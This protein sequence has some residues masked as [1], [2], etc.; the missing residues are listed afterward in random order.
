MKPA[1]FVYYQPESIE[2]TTS[3]LAEHGDDGKILAGGQSLIPMMNLRLAQP[4]VLIDITKVPGIAD[5]RINGEIRVGTLSRQ[6]SVL[7]SPE[8]Q[9][10]A[11]LIPEALK[12]VGH[13]ANRNRGTFGG[14]IAHADAAAELPAVLLALNGKIVAKSSSKERTIGAD[15]FFESY[16]TTALSSEELLCEVL[17][18]KTEPETTVWGFTEFSRRHGDFALAGVAFTAQMRGANIDSARIALLGVA[19]R[20]VRAIEA[21]NALNGQPFP[22]PAASREIGFLAA[23]ELD[24]PFDQHGSSEYR[25]EL[26]ATLVKRVINQACAERKNS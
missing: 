18:P 23:A 15:D 21:E 5:I 1:P 4:S 7:G 2:E 12:W 9:K 26:A 6:A 11:P 24:P 22:D 20:A 14:S 25:K 3:L 19:D 10:A 13:A 16:L 17:I 8:V